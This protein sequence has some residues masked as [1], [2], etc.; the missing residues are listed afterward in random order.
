MKLT[1]TT[2]AILKGLFGEYGAK[3]IAQMENDNAQASENIFAKIQHLCESVTTPKFA[4]VTY[5]DKT[6]GETSR[7]VMVLGG[8]YGSLLKSALTEMEVCNLAEI[9][10]EK[11]RF[12]WVK[13]VQVPVTLEH[14]QEAHAKHVASLRES[15]AKDGTGESNSAYTKAGIYST[16]APGIRVNENDGTLELF[17][18]EQSK[19][20]IIPGNYV[21][22][23][24]NPVTVARNAL[25]KLTRL[26][27][28]KTL[29]L[30]AGN[31]VSFKLNGET[32][33]FGN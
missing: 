5:C 29:A 15:L 1:E 8:S 18:V 6:H 4:G 11:T 28:F 16:V 14:F 25:K 2:K 19:V 22:V 23:K 7:R 10:A 26:G 9:H 32:V 20:V 21:P 3:V 17:G 30:D 31:A 13:G 27:K 12:G 24:S 33:D